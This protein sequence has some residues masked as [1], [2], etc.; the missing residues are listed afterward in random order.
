MPTSI[1]Q[2]SGRETF[3]SNWGFLCTAASSA[4]GLGN[5]WS[6]PTLAAN[7][8]GMAFIVA[9]IAITFL[10]AWPL[11][12]LELTAGRFGQTDNVEIMQKMAN[13]GG[14]RLAITSGNLALIFIL[15]AAALYSVVGGWVLAR[16]LHDK[17]KRRDGF[18]L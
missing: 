2:I 1:Q 6:F 8:G 18:L 7:H 17:Q 3:S 4:I 11:L 14:K 15:T 10:L 12:T 5:I 9:Y 16:I 13:K